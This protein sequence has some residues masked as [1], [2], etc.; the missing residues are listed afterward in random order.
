M[1]AIHRRHRN[2]N[3]VGFLLWLNGYSVSDQYV[4]G[5]LTKQAMAFDRIIEK[6]RRFRRKLNSDDEE[7]EERAWDELMKVGSASISIK[8]VRRIRKRVGRNEFDAL[9]RLFLDILDDDGAASPDNENDER[10][11]RKAMGIH[12]VSPRLFQGA[13]KWLL[14]PLDDLMEHLSDVLARRRFVEIVEETERRTFDQTRDEFRCLMVGI[15]QLARTVKRFVNVKIPLFEVVS[16]IIELAQP[17][18]LAFMLISWCNM[19]TRPWASGYPEILD[20]LR[21]WSV[22]ASRGGC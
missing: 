13:L 1:C 12:H 8:F 6:L 17:R 21:A 14:D 18:D 15:S 16:E 11:L 3:D 7:E 5:Y 10:N 4:T 19:R 20:A 2:L 22:P 9:M